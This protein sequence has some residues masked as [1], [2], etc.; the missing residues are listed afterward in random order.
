M[1]SVGDC[2]GLVA[3][4]DYQVVVVAVGGFVSEIVAAGDDGTVLGVAGIDDDDLVVD[5]GVAGA[6]QLGPEI[7][8]RHP[9][10]GGPDHHDAA[11]VPAGP[12][13]RGW[14]QF[15]RDALGVNI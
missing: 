5:D 6:E 12:P 13:N 11:A 14:R 10:R 3:P 15:V 2:Q 8:E 4:H 9:Y 1:H 7:A